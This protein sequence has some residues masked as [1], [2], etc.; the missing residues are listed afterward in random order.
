MQTATQGLTKEQQLDQLMDQHRALKARL[1]E[2]DKH[3]S[4]SSAEQVERA[5]L[6]KMKLRTKER[7]L[8]LQQH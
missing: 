8:L 7:I 3:L 5:Q 4:L 2:L 1:H 6:K